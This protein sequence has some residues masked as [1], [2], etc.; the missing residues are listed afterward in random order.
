MMRSMPANTFSLSQLVHHARLADD[1]ALV[2]QLAPDAARQ[3]AAVG[4]HIEAAGLFAIAIEFID[5]Q[6]ASTVELFERHAYEC[7]LT[8]Q[9]KPAIAS[10]RKALEIWRR[11]K[12]VLREGDALRF[13][14]RLLWYQ[15]KSDEVDRVALEAVQVLENGF[16]TRERALGYSNLSQLFML[17]DNADQCIHWGNKAIELATRMNDQEILC[18]ALNNVGAVMIKF[19]GREEEGKHNL[20][21]SLA[22]ALKYNFQE[23]AARAYT[24]FS[25][26]Y[27]YTK[28][29]EQA[30]RSFDEGIRYCEEHD[31]MSWTYYMLSE[32]SQML[33]S[34]GNVN[35]AESVAER[36]FR[37]TN[38]PN[39]VR[40]GSAV[41][42]ARIKMRRGEFDEAKALLE[43]AKL[44]AFPTNEPI[45]IVPVLSALIELSWL[46]GK[47]PPMADIDHAEQNIFSR[48]DQSWHYSELAYWKHKAGLDLAPEVSRYAGPFQYEANSD[49][50]GAVKEWRRIGAVY[51]HAIACFY[52]DEKHQKNAIQLLNDS[53]FAATSDLLKRKLKLSG[54]KNIPRGPHESTRSNAAQLTNRQV[55]ILRLLQAG[56]QNKEIAEK[57][58]ISLKTVDAHVSAILS[59]LEVNTRARAVLEG[60]RLG[61]I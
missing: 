4:A 54:V 21:T 57:L 28:Q 31:L 7:Y 1:R 13:L 22:L 27:V 32:K 24:N 60:Q 3:A 30:R 29:Y 20:Q 19:P 48:K 26:V 34:T 43:E 36:L 50:A 33:L 35:E 25:S 51:E 45:R 46:T 42:L 15:G 8:N 56:N 47:T 44:L 52:L 38:H 37:N 9:L 39:M 17:A 2:A 58:F 53:G 16:P 61:I 41:T 14:S 59:K 23:H 49:F 18:H 10:Q 12:V 11:R 5:P 6:D 55:E 40:I